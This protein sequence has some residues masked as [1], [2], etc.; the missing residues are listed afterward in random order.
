NSMTAQLTSPPQASVIRGR[1]SARLA[2]NESGTPGSK[3]KSKA[4]EPA[5]TSAAAMSF[6]ANASA[7]VEL[8]SE[9]LDVDDKKKVAVF[10]GSVE[11]KQDT[12]EIRCA[13]L[14]AF[15]M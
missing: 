1:I 4:A 6:E 5:A 12:V 2:R 13:E 9:S 3:R 10:R 8:T 11:A 15:Y 14:S 7:P